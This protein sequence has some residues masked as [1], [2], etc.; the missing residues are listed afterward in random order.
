MK[1]NYFITNFLYSAINLMILCTLLLILL[2]LFN[3]VILFEHLKFIKYYPSNIHLK[4]S[5]YLIFD[6]FNNSYFMLINYL[7]CYIL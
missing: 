6:K 2:I 7:E 5:C 3:Y 1:G 4:Y